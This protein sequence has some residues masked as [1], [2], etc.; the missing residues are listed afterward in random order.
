MNADCLF[1]QIARGEIPARLVLQDDRYLAFQDIDPKA[2]THV[3][4]IPRGH[5]SSLDA[6]DDVALLGGLLAFARRVARDRGVAESG[7]RTVINTNRD[8]GQS[9]AHLHAHI[10][11]GRRMTWP[12]G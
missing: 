7:Y 2:P 3:L 8:G 9:V 4:V 1:C 5:V 11:G 12:P 10:L 6:T